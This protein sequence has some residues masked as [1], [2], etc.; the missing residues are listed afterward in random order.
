[1]AWPKR[2]SDR[3]EEVVAGAAL[4]GLD[5]DLDRHAGGQRHVGAGCERRAVEAD[6]GVE[7][8]G[9]VA[10]VLEQVGGD[11]DHLAVSTGALARR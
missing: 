9:A 10:V 8:G 7:I 11:V 6:A 3:L 1:M 4:A 2:R 5:R